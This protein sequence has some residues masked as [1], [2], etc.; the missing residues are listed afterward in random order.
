MFCRYYNW[1]L[2]NKRLNEVSLEALKNLQYKKKMSEVF[3]YI[4]KITNP[5]ILVQH[6]WLIQ[7][8]NYKISIS[9]SKDKYSEHI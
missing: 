2:Q 7:D 8:S 9:K 4:L 5:K 1:L 3:S 6:V